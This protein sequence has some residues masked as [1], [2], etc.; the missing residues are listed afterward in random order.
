M[1]VCVRLSD[2]YSR[3]PNPLYVCCLVLQIFWVTYLSSVANK[4]QDSRHLKLDPA[5]AQKEL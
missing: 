2:F 5:L 3:L 1:S 4:K